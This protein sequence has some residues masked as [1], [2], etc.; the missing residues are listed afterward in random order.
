MNLLNQSLCRAKSIYSA[1]G[2]YRDNISLSIVRNS[3]EI[4]VAIRNLAFGPQLRFRLQSRVFSKTA[5]ISM[6]H[7]RNEYQNNDLGTYSNKD[8][9]L[10][11]RLWALFISKQRLRVLFISKQRLRALFLVL[12]TRPKLQST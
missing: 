6:S 8:Q 2:I 1:L 4:L 9:V 3:A 10:K 5:I 7:Y 11:Q 12:K